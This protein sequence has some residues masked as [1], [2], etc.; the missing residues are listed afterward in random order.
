MITNHI[1]KIS[2]KLKTTEDVFCFL[3]GLIKIDQLVTPGELIALY[4]WF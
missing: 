3:M 2:F 1:D 4:S